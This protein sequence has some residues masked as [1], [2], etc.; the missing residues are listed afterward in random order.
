MHIYRISILIEYEHTLHN[1]QGELTAVFNLV[2][3]YRFIQ[4]NREELAR[5]EVHDTGKPI[6]EARFD[7]DGCADSMEF[8][9]GLAPTISGTSA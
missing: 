3:F 1:L 9:A 5:A 4:A 6:W 7:I 8:F 2:K